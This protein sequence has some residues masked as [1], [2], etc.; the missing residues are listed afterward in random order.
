MRKLSTIFV[1][2]LMSLS[3]MATDYS[4]NLTVSINGESGV[5]PATI[6]INENE[7]KYNLSL[8]NFVLGEGEGAIA[9]GN[10]VIENVAPAA[11]AGL[12]TLYVNK[13][14]QIQAGD[15]D[16]VAADAWLGPQ[17][18]NVPVQMNARFTGD[19]LLVVSI[20]IDMQATLGQTI[21]VDF[22]NVGNHFQMPNSDFETWSDK[23]NAPKNWHGFESCVTATFTGAAKT[24]IKLNPSNWARP[25][26]AGQKSAVLTG[27]KFF[28]IVANG[29]MTNGIL[30]ATSTTAT[31]PANHSESYL[32]DTRTDAN[33]DPFYTAIKAKPDGVKF[34]ARFTQAD[35]SQCA[36]Y[37]YAAFNAVITDGTYYQ[38]PEDKEYTNKVGVATAKGSEMAVGGWREVSCNFDYD[39]YA[40]NGAEP[41]AIL[42]TF[43]T[44]ATPGKGSAI[45]EGG[46]LGIA[47]KLTKADSLFVDDL[48]FV[49]NAGIKSISFKDEALDLAAVA[50][51][52]IN[53][54]EGEN[55]AIDDFV[56]VKEGA[57]SKVTTLIEETEEGYDVVITVV[58]AD[59]MKA[60]SVA[61]SLIKPSQPI[62]MGD[63]D[64]NGILDVTDITMLINIVLGTSETQPA[65]D[66]DGN[67]SV[68]VSD[69]T[70]LVQ[71]VLG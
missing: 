62:M 30:N 66:L 33:G 11:T 35:A 52:G 42:M 61:F 31:D 34:W 19:G 65:A 58:S 23:N 36:D 40:A 9:V 16:G 47:A 53:L 68:D 59:L 54:A 64:G 3:A 2:A 28:G 29:T 39:S 70:K 14:I 4:G 56:V 27:N 50:A 63:L 10:V 25:G 60:E 71:L 51:N 24:D 49:Y 5:M 26:S 48:E 41:K 8:N 38:D 13:N 43:S 57:D 45:L 67:G 12:T 15:L 17:L 18:G 1:A 46:F 37:P 7:G 32:T 44:N 55:I 6:S 20:N 69:V 21:K 22:E